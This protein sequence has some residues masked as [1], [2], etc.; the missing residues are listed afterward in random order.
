[1]SSTTSLANPTGHTPNDAEESTP[2]YLLNKNMPFNAPPEIHAE[3]LKQLVAIDG[4]RN[5]VER[6]LMLDKTLWSLALPHFYGEMYITSLKA[7]E[8]ALLALKVHPQLEEHIHTLHIL[9]QPPP[10]L[11]HFHPSMKRLAEYDFTETIPTNRRALVG[12]LIS[13]SATSIR[14]L[15]IIG[16]LFSDEVTIPVLRS[17][18]INLTEL[19]APIHFLA[20][21]N[22][23]F[24]LR[25]SYDPAS[26][27]RDQNFPNLLSVW[28]W[29]TEPADDQEVDQYMMD[30]RNLT[31]LCRL[32]ITFRQLDSYSILAYLRYLKVGPSVGCI[33]V[34]IATIPSMF[35]LAYVIYDAYFFDPRVIFV[36]SRPLSVSFQ[37]SISICAGDDAPFIYDLL[38]VPASS[39]QP[40]WEM[41]V[42]KVQARRLF[43][44]ET[45]WVFPSGVSHVVERGVGPFKRDKETEGFNDLAPPLEPSTP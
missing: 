38:M 15:A 18:F 7:L 10:A 1:M 5:N 36:Q 20:S 24:V 45:G 23:P 8:S 13:K 41:I 33:A 12:R 34:D 14:S 6:I 42:D 35:P 32:A 22:S 16:D 27:E 3:V 21:P 25:A 11:G 4:P 30:V 43:A 31:T 28:T 37:N 17:T 9:V 29:I 26:N 19:A 40:T 39:V 2:Q 44:Q